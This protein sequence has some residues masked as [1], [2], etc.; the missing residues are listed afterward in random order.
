M[1]AFPDMPV[2]I[3]GFLAWRTRLDIEDSPMQNI[4]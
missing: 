2:P 4:K 3:T 1:K